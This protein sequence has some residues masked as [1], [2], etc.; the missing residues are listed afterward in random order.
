[1]NKLRLFMRFFTII[2]ITIFAN[3]VA[4]NKLSLS[5]IPLTYSVIG[6][7]H[8]KTQEGKNE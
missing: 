1:M 6:T 5:L 8:I 3:L 4:T 2:M 7:F